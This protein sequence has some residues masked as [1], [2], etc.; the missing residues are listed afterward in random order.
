MA[1]SCVF[2]PRAGSTG[3]GEHCVCFHA[4]AKQNRGFGGTFKQSGKIQQC[5]VNLL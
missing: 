4:F 3:Q 2:S 5:E 1:G